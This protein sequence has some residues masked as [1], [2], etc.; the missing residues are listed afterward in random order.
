VF[1]LHEGTLHIMQKIVSYMAIRG[2]SLVAKIREL[3]NAYIGKEM[4][5]LNDI[6]SM[7]YMTSQTLRRKLASVGVN[8]QT[9]KNQFRCDIAMNLLKL[10]ELTIE[11]ISEKVGFSEQ[12]TF[13]RA[14]KKW[15]GITPGEYRNQYLA[16]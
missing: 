4:P 2:Q 16:A 11:E 1:L 7:L 12:S 6:A 10:P 14:F 13:Y 5:T 3:M 8:F 15:T 9:L